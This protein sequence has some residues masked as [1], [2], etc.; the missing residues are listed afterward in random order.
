MKRVM[1]KTQRQMIL[2]IVCCFTLLLL[3]PAY[4]A[5]AADV[6][7][8]ASDNLS[9][10]LKSVSELV[11]TDGGYMRVFY[12]G[13]KIGIEYYD[14]NFNIQSKR[15]LDME[16]DIWGGF[17]A[18]SDAYYLVEGQVNTAESD[19]AEVIRV[20]KYDT[21]WNKKG[22][23]NITGNPEI[24]GGEVRE[25]FDYGCVEMAE[26]NGVLYIVT[27]HEG[28]VDPVYKQG[29]QGFLMIA[30]DEP[31]MTGSIV[32]SDL[33]H[34]FA[35]YITAKDSNLYV[36]EQ[37]EGSRYTKLS[38]YDTGNLKGSSLPVFEYGGDRTSAWA[39]S[40]YASVDG[41]EVS[42]DNVLC[43]GTSIDQSQY[44]SVS[45][46]M[47]HN[48]YLTVTP[49]S[50]FSKSATTV[51]WL[52]DY[53]GDG[54]CFMGT[55]ITKIND[56]RFMVSWEESGMNPIVDT[57]D[58]LS[59]YVLHYVFLDGEGNK[60]SREFTEAAPISD[61]Q[62]IVKG[63]QIVY[64]A[65]NANMVNFYSID[66]ESGEFA[67]KVYRVAGENATWDFDN[68][69]LTISGTGPMTMDTTAHYRSPV[70]SASGGG[71]YS[72]SDNAW[73]AI[74]EKVSKIVVD[75]GITDIPENAFEYFNS[76]E[77][78]EIES[79][80]KSIGKEAFYRCN[81][82]KKIT[83]P[84]SV[85]SI[86]ED[87]LWTGYY[88]ISDES[89]VVRATIYAPQDS[90]AAAYAKEN[91]ISYRSGDDQS[92]DEGG[93]KEEDK[94]TGK[95]NDN[96]NEDTK[97]TISILKAAVSGIK[98]SYAYNGREQTPEVTVKL[99][100][101][102]LRKDTDYTLSYINN[103]DTGKATIKIEGENAYRG[104]I[105]KTF[106]IVPKKAVI[107]KVKPLGIGSVK[108]TWKKDSQASGYQIQYAR[109][110]KFTQ[111]KKNVNMTKNSTVSKKISK[112]VRGKK[113]YVRVRSYKKIDGKKCYG[114][115]SK[116]VKVTVK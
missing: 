53:T 52:T 4:T 22:T 31:S 106:K 109:N 42:S 76:L 41:M 88:W 2:L 80:V 110:A 95:E 13:D 114:A 57:D 69:V 68:G 65:S 97:D 11:A 9:V 73:K 43:L 49:I 90:Y 115:W 23:A 54:K 63:S 6:W 7:P 101:K 81:I 34:S 48:I 89:H 51:K 94:E 79:G 40:C 60:I 102:T 61:C 25:P 67:K 62:P 96:G 30:V 83:I 116:T 85:T 93:S 29:H 47:A 27:G 18:G 20:I 21:D 10:R 46:D 58:G 35:Q 56:N 100:S 37:S 92:G 78:V 1:K 44:D 28:Y 111:S 104:T 71:V 113:Y 103:I 3:V 50:D 91:G 99:G 8:T 15:F 17:Y 12:N 77:E 98:K 74:R 66:A 87:F 75:G 33:W 16:L 82:L 32:A 84:A 5:K 39:I 70:S 45:S 59:A 107:A 14:D 38:K 36:L 19:T 26:Y 86:G 64:Y 108:V 55:K 24:F 72:S 105:E 112:L